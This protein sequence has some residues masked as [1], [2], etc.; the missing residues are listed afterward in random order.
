MSEINQKERLTYFEGRLDEAKRKALA[1]EPFSSE[2]S[3]GFTT[4]KSK[5]WVEIIKIIQ[6]RIARIREKQPLE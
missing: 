5:N 1:K 2:F 3:A 4:E 6:D